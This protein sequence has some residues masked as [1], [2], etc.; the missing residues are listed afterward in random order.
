MRKAFLQAPK[1][2][3]IDYPLLDVRTDPALG[4][5]ICTP[6]VISVPNWAWEIQPD[7][8]GAARIACFFAHHTGQGI[9]LAVAETPEGPWRVISMASPGLRETPFV[10]SDLVVPE[11]PHQPDWMDLS[12][13][14]ARARAG[15]RA[16]PG[17]PWHLIAHIASPDVHIEDDSE[18]FWMTY[19]GLL[20]NL[21]QGTRL[22]TSKDGVFWESGDED[23]API[24]GPAYFRGIKGQDGARYAL[25]L[26]GSLLRAEHVEGPYEQGPQLVPP[27]AKGRPVR[28]I[29]GHV[30][31]QALHLFFTRIGDAPEQIYHAA[32]DMAADWKQW[33]VDQETLLL[34]PNRAWEGGALP[35]TASQIGA[36]ITREPALRDPAVYVAADHQCYLFYCGG[37]ESSLCAAKLEWPC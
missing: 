24:L 18:R 1:A 4:G 33:H 21:E 13:E 7:L 14:E 35:I 30:R 8:Y 22:A 37:G 32:V 28:H 10:H 20:P 34:A 26:G 36:A 31:G 19:H 17:P 27:D 23:S 2:T 29:E 12:T 9:R 15:L 6:S 3:R 16:G 25:A 5:N 11:E